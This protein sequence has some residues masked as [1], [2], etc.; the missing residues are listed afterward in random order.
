MTIRYHKGDLPDLSAYETASAVAV[1]SET[2]GLNPHRDRLCVVQLS[3]GDGSADVV[4][5]ARGQTEAPN[6]ATL[7]TDPTNRRFSTSRGL[8]LLFFVTIWG[9]MSHRSG[10]PKSLRNWCALTLTAMD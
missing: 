1:D 8:T 4:Q 7:F 2:L 10:A 9:F 6:L 3:P 5:I